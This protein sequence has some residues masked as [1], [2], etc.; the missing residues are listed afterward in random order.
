M[1]LELVVDD[2]PVTVEVDP[3]FTTVRIGDRSYPIRV[4]EAGGARIELE[5]GGVKVVLE[6]WPAVT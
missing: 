3:T 1:R 4:V 5:I 6:G 2:R